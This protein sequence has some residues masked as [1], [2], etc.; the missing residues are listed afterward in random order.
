M[1]NFFKI[2]RRKEAFLTPS[3]QNHDFMKEMHA[4]AGY[5]IDMN[6]NYQRT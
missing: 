6:L 2:F 3:K 1:Q 4:N 5:I